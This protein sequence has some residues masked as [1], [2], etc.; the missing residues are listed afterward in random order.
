MSSFIHTITSADKAILQQARS[1]WRPQ[2]KNHEDSWGYIIQATRNMGGRWYDPVTQSLVFFGRKPLDNN[3]LVIPNFFAEPEHLKSIIEEL[4]LTFNVS[5]T[6]L[7]N[8]NPQDIEK[9]TPYGFWQYYANEQWDD[10]SRFDDQTYPQLV[11]DLKV[12]AEKKGPG[13]GE[14]RRC[15]HKVSFTSIRSYN[16]KDRDAV[17]SIFKEKDADKFLP[18]QFWGMYYESHKMFPDAD[19]EK[20][21]ITDKKTDKVLGF[22]ATSDISST[23][24]AMVAGIFAPGIKLESVWGLYS[25]LL[26]KH[27]QGFKFANVGG[28]ETKETYN[29]VRRAFRPVE[30]LQRI[31]LV[32]E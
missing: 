32:Y 1:Y 27:Q 5:K 22:T 24:S 25:T 26:I 9:F 3:T 7:K 23:T 17:L 8:I 18:K 2:S 14:L 28:F 12:L 4:Q 29:F 11:I 15:L 20:F 19:I 31:H 21:V 10:F 30:E 6:V 13:Y 16:D